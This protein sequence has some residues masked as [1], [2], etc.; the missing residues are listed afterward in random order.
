VRGILLPA[1]RVGIPLPSRGA[2]VHARQPR[3]PRRRRRVVLFP[4]DEARAA[5][6]GGPVPATARRVPQAG[7]EF[8]P[9]HGVLRREVLRRGR[10]N[11]SLYRVLDVRECRRGTV[12]CLTDLGE[13]VPRNRSL[14]VAAL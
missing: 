14:T 7:G 8:T 9:A 6:R 3:N 12:G 2:A 1:F 5:H 13:T 4:L 10:M 11:P